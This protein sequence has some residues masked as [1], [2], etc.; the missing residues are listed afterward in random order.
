MP[1][2]QKNAF[3]QSGVYSVEGTLKDEQ[4]QALKKWIDDFYTGP[5]SAGGV[6]VLDHGAKF[7]ETKMK[8]TDA[9]TLETRKY[10]VEEIC[11]GFRVNPIMVGAESK[12]TTYA[13]AEQMFLAHLI[14]TLAPWYTRLEQSINARLLTQKQRD[15]GIY[16]NFVEEGLLRGS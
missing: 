7:L 5:D 10:Q 2:F 3:S 14:H 16:A 11:R 15:E 1:K 9:Q 4:Y 6:M 8:G 12:N 13:S